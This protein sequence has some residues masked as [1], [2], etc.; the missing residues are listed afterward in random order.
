MVTTQSPVDKRSSTMRVRLTRSLSLVNPPV[1]S[2]AGVRKVVRRAQFNCFVAAISCGVMGSLLLLGG[3]AFL[4]PRQVLA[5]AIVLFVGAFIEFVL[6][7]F[8]FA[9]IFWKPRR[10][11]NLM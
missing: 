5:A 4:H 6:A 3:F 7:L 11:V 2:C 1:E 9:T 10:C 8:A